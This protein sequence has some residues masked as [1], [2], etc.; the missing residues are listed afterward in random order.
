[1]DPKPPK[2][3]F[4]PKG[5]T[6]EKKFNSKFQ[7]LAKMIAPPPSDHQLEKK[8]DP[9]STQKCSHVMKTCL[10]SLSIFL[11]P[12]PPSTLPEKSSILFR[13]YLT[14]FLDVWGVK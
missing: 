10:A 11:N 4:F 2:N 7:S 8:I 1:M 5:F 3:Y 9:W 13:H 14:I 12:I 6:K